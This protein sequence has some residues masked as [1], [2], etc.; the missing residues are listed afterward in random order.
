MEKF[1]KVVEVKKI[2][3]RNCLDLE[4]NHPDHNYWQNGLLGSNSH[5]FAYSKMTALTVY[6]K[7]NYPKE[8]FKWALELA[9][10]GKKTKQEGIAE[11]VQ[12]LPRFDIKLL[13]PSLV[14]SSTVFSI[15]GDA[16]RHGLCSIK[17]VSHKKIEHLQSFINKEKANLFQIFQ[18]ADQSK[19]GVDVCTSL[20]EIGCIDDF[21]PRQLDDEGLPTDKPDRQKAV[22]FL[23]IWKA[24]T[25]RE[26]IYCIANGENFDF[27]L[28]KMLKSYLS[29]TGSNGK[30]FGTEKRLKTLREKVSPFFQIYRENIKNPMVSQYLFEKK[31][32]GYC[33]STTL[34][35]L[36]REYDDLTKIGAVKTEKYEGELVKIMAEVVEVKTGVSKAKKSKYAK[37]TLSDETG[38]MNAMIFNDKWESYLAEFGEPKEGQIIYVRGKKSGG[39]DP[40]IFTD[41]MSVQFLKIYQRVSDL[42]GL[43]KEV[44]NAEISAS[45]ES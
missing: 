41:H 26:K 8:F 18:A 13:P 6:L 1:L 38:S 42:K 16:I 25:D 31:L 20:I 30:T 10:G 45:V 4:V 36:F 39:E 7:F 5:A 2:G 19:L 17:G 43:E 40:I 27:D 33:P 22:Y 28:T 29:W 44:D 32:L 34:S 21:S 12:E 9:G 11:I 15:E 23:K 35:D 37:I 24:L 3:Q 14:K